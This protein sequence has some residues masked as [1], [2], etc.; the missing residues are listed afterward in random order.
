VIDLE[1]VST[2]WDNRCVQIVQELHGI[3]LDD[4]A[5]IKNDKAAT[6]TAKAEVSRQLLEFADILGM[7]EA[8][9]RNEYWILKGRGYDITL[10]E[11]YAAGLVIPGYNDPEEDEQEC[12]F[13][14]GHDFDSGECVDGIVVSTC[15]ECGAEIWETELDD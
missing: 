4:S 8:L 15:R 14:Y 12:G 6:R 1:T 7:M 11:M 2:L 13:T 5:E 9:V 3:H 10:E